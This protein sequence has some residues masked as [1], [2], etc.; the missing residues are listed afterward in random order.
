MDENGRVQTRTKT[1]YVSGEATSQWREEYTY[2]GNTVRMK[3]YNSNHNLPAS[4][5]VEQYD[6][7]GNLLKREDYKNF[8]DENGSLS[9]QN[10]IRWEYRYREIQVP[11]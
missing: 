2:E 9:K 8:Y 10:V 1:T 6:E 7:N 5:A 3:W 4:E 11:A